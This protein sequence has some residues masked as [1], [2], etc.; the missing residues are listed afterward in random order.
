[1][2]LSGRLCAISDAARLFLSPS[3]FSIS[4]PLSSPAGHP[5]FFPPPPPPRFLQH[6]R[7]VSAV[8]GSYL[9]RDTYTIIEFSP[10]F[11]P[12][13]LVSFSRLPLSGHIPVTITRYSMYP[14]PF[15]NLF[16]PC[17]TRIGKDVSCCIPCSVGG[18]VNSLFHYVSYRISSGRLSFF[19]L[20]TLNISIIYPAYVME[21]FRRFFFF[22][23]L[24][25]LR[26]TRLK[27]SHSSRI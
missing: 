5:C 22:Y 25:Y 21:V 18:P 7:Q 27:F 12:P 11:F 19:K 17:R 20:V 2:K 10:F 4:L 23:F 14:F 9:R 13:L 6:A 24:F 15:R 16:L 3:P 1:M 26:D 8:D